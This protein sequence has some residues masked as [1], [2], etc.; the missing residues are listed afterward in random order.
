MEIL[1]K[2]MEHVN[3]LEQNLKRAKDNDIKTLS[4]SMDYNSALSN[5]ICKRVEEKKNLLDALLRELKEIPGAKDIPT[6]IKK[7]EEFHDTYVEYSKPELSNKKMLDILSELE[8]ILPGTVVKKQAVEFKSLKIPE[9]IRNEIEIDSR[10]LMRCYETGC[11][12]AAVIICGR[13][14]EVALHRKYF[15]VTGNDILETNP[16]IGLGKLIA[17]LKENEVFF[18]PGLMDQIH[19]INKV[20]IHS[21]HRKQEVY[22][23]SDAQT[24]AMMLY[25]KDIINRLF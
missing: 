7:L 11:F 8:K 13:M 25:T 19:M 16:G 14:L 17:R 3:S 18:D 2:I 20:R 5:E 22:E 23:P 10:E 9:A 4:K 6:I 21:V 24:Q 1:G 12:R 15:D